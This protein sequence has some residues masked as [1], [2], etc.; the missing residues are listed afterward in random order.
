MKGQDGELL[1]ES[2]DLQ[3]FLV[4]GMLVAFHLP[5]HFDFVRILFLVGLHGNL[6]CRSRPAWR[7]SVRYPLSCSAGMW[8]SFSLWVVDDFAYGLMDGAGAALNGPNLRSCLADLPGNPEPVPEDSREPVGSNND[9][10]LDRRALDFPYHQ[11]A[12]VARNGFVGSAVATDHPKTALPSEGPAEVE[13]V[14][15]RI[16]P[17]LG[18]ERREE[19][20]PLSGLG[21]GVYECSFHSSSK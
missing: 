12:V 6:R 4:G 13:L 7:V 17:A 2:D 21:V 14:V 1:E 8:Y 18:H 5:N 20:L 3:G 10:D 11:A 9:D 16:G 15:V 19:V